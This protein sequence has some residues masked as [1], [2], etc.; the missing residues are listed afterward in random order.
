MVSMSTPVAL[1]SFLICI[2]RT[3]HRLGDTLS[4]LA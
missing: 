3:V 2:E 4:W 1:E